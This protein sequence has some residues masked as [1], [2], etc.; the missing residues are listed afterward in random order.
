MS[1]KKKARATAKP[2]PPKVNPIKKILM[3]PISLIIIGGVV[4]AYS[5]LQKPN[6]PVAVIQL[7]KGGTIEME[8][9][10]KETPI[11]ANNFIKLVN[12]KFYDGLKFHRVE[13][14]FV[15][16]TGDPEG[17]GT[18]GPGYTIKDEKSPYKHVRGAVGM[19]KSSLPDSAGS[20]W[21]ICLDDASFLDG[22]YTVFGK[23]IKGMEYVDK[24]EVG[25][26]M[27]SVTMKQ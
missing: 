18:G 23:V 1:K 14:G 5:A 22:N 13:P 26:K 9:Y 12:E 21:Y 4:L 24:I 2:A 8:L 16:Q 7:E 6:N 15:V 10:P 17:T 25:D 3:I 27:K 20:Q 19:A 11:T